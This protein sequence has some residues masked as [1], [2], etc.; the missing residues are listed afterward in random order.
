MSKLCFQKLQII[1]FSS[2]SLDNCQSSNMPHKRAN[3]AARQA[4]RFTTGQ[5]LAPAADDGMFSQLPKGAMRILQGGKIHEEYHKRREAQKRLQEAALTKAKGK[6]RASSDDQITT[7]DLKIRA[8]EKLK[9]F[10]ARVEQ[11]MASD[12]HASFKSATRSTINARNRA[13]RKARAAGI[14]PDADPEDLE[15]QETKRKAKADKAAAHEAAQPSSADLRR[16]RQLMEQTGEIRD[17]AK[18]TQIKK[19]NDIALAPPKLTKAPRGESLQAKTRK[20]ILKAKITGKDEVQAERNA[21]TAENARQRGRVPQQ[22]Q[23]R[24]R[25]DD[26]TEAQTIPKPSMARQ[27]LLEQ[28]REKAIKAY[29]QAK[30]KKIQAVEMKRAQKTAA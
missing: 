4:K 13:K 26:D 12:I 30:E 6:S 19:I 20:A 28:E 14:D 3:H 2:S 18:A 15:Q 27:R 8:G 7:D 1:L 23:K 21:K 11:A 25:E 17:F 16:Q 29:R 24:N 22:A 10:N 5:D 9:D